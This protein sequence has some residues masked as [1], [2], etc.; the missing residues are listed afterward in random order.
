[1]LFNPLWDKGTIINWFEDQG[2][3]TFDYFSVGNC[4]LAQYL[5]FRGVVFPV[6]GTRSW[7]GLRWG[8]VP[9]WGKLPRYANTAVIRSYEY[10]IHEY[11]FRK[12]AA[13]FRRFWDWPAKA[14]PG[15]SKPKVTGFESP[16]GR[17]ILGDAM[18]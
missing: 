15:I 11:T 5:K 17:H 13:L 16:A 8:I 10:S 2:D 9:M 14:A 1:M 12:A 18:T 3:R 7:F 6:V 4:A